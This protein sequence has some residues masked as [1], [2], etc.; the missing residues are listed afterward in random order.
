MSEARDVPWS[1]RDPSIEPSYLVI[2]AHDLPCSPR[3]PSIDASDPA[4]DART[5]LCSRGDSQIAPARPTFA[6][7]SAVT[8][9]GIR[10]RSW[11]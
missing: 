1:A 4:G 5:S 2:E 7:H 11:R 9:D 10:R 3:Y 8:G 6:R